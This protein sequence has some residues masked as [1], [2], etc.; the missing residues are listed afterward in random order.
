MAVDHNEGQVDPLG[1]ESYEHL[2]E[3]YS[4]FAP[5][6]ADEVLPGTVLG[7]KGKD[8]I[9]D[10][11]YKSEGI[12]PIE[13][14]LSPSGELTVHVGD[15][16]DVMI[17]PSEQIEGYVLL[18]HTRAAR[19]RIWDNL[20]KAYEN[21]LVLSGRV[22][23][24]VKG[25]LAV[26]VGIKA[27]MPG[28]QADPRP[29]HNLDSLVGQDV[30][31]KIIKLN[32]RRGNVVVSRK[33]AVEEEI[34][35]RKSVTLEH[36]A[37]GAVVTGIVKNLTDYGAFIDLG[38]IDG[39]L[40]VTDMSYGRITHPSELL[41]VNQE[42][43][44]KVLKFDRHKERVSLGL[45]QLEPDPWDTV[46][47]RYPVQTRV[48][49]RVVN[50]TD[51]GAFVELEPGVEGLIHISEMT[52]SR[53]MKHPS[54]VVKPGDQVEAVVLEVH[55]KDRRI[56]LGLKQLEP[57]PWTTIDKR[58]SVGSVVEGRVRNM[59]DFG[60][61]IE[62]EEGID[63]LVHV[64]DLSWTKRVKHPSE[65]L[66]KGQIVQAVILNI[67][68]GSHRLSLGIKQLQP[69]AWESYFQN[70]QVGDTVHGRVCRLASFGGFVELA[71]GVEGLCHFS[72]VP[73][74]SGRRAAEEPP[75]RINDEFDFKIVKMSEAEKKI[76]LSLRAVADEEE[77]TRLED[78]QRQ[79]AAAT[80]TIEE[81]M[82]L[83]DRN[84]E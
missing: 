2:L 61:F 28:S 67:D 36:L 22:L 9:I 81:V 53:R 39:L 46:V 60:A 55:P 80:S 32:R 45:K 57:N 43:S 63:G 13:Q 59:T 69:D 3:D 78:Y 82:S 62:I 75:L 12:V 58:Y 27:F 11:G 31:V 79:A 6:A 30:P 23:G 66:K 33:A 64:S 16:V 84:L 21:Q 50:V 52:W 19:L 40:H 35:V 5:P 25:G 56:S 7:I 48:I 42:L 49:G 29:V 8:V 47:E 73:G 20:D 65:A 24:R 71:E 38:G 76:G 83:K 44:V 34:N 26:D 15:A 4:H 70:H 68:S 54:K 1:S 10:F 41:H 14:F 18:S 72:E 17:D 77:K 51:Y 74:Y 37:E